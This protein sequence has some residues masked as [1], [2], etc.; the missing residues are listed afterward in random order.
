VLNSSGENFI[1][2]GILAGDAVYIRS[3]DGSIDGVYETVSV[4]SETQLEVSV[5]R[6]GSESEAVSPGDNADVYYHICTY[7]PQA[8]DV[9]FEISE[10]FGLGPGSSTSRYHVEDIMDKEVLR[11]VSV[12]AVISMVYASLSSGDDSEGL[13]KKS[14]YYRRLYEKARERCRVS[15]DSGDD[16]KAEV[17]IVGGS[18]RL[19]RD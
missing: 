14:L 12:F 13:W 10:Y 3:S 8:W 18:L 16:G 7:R 2:K 6:A 17:T 9:M 5:V 15:I 19:T 11:Q 4:N 1:S